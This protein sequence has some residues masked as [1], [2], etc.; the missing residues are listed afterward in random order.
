M[1]IGR[2]TLESR[3]EDGGAIPISSRWNNT[4][5]TGRKGYPLRFRFRTWFS[6][7]STHGHS[8]LLLG[9]HGRLGKWPLTP[10]LT[11]ATIP[12]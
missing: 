11:L 7:T 8:Q 12:L 3:D 1:V 4:Y 5:D 10:S 2:N 6:L 9:L